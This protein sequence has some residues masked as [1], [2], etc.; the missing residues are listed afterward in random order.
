MT[1]K[2][3]SVTIKEGRDSGKVFKI[4]EWPATRVE[5]WALRGAFGLGKAGVE[6][7]SQ[8]LEL[9]APAIAYFVGTQVLKMPSRLGIRLANELMECVK[10]AEDT[11]DRSLV[12]QD[13]EDYQTRF[14][15]KMEVLKLHFG[16]FASAASRSSA[17]PASGT[18]PLKP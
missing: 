11:M 7:P 10:R 18:P 16:F 8:I 3:L 4:T 13:I 6:I 15:L 1:L 17:P 5:D 14:K 12:E 9:G 2:T